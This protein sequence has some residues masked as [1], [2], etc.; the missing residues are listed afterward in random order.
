MPD[1]SVVLLGLLLVAVLY[2]MVG[3][4]GASGYLAVLSLTTIG[5]EAIA[6]TSLMLNLF[7]AGISFA[8]YAHAKNFSWSLTWPFLVSAIPLSYLGATLKLKPEFYSLL[9][10]VVLLLA[11]GRLFWK[12]KSAEDTREP[13]VW[14]ATL[15]GGGIG[16]LSGMV[17]VGGGIFL[18]PV[19][20]LLRW[21]DPKQTAAVS[22]IFI[23]ANSCAGLVGRWNVDTLSFAPGVGWMILVCVVGSV[24]GSYVGAKKMAPIWIRYAL[25]CVLVTAAVKLLI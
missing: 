24:V 20:L 14:K 4:G 17:G 13:V 2:S 9:L 21:A 18:S 1:S 8:F 22:S 25:G 7:V 15:I 23:F 11:A 6:S 16:F 19:L 3:H 10:G 12:P 5:A